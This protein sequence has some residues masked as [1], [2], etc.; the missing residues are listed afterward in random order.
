MTL[1]VLIILC[2]SLLQI[3]IYRTQLKR[4]AEQA[5][6]LPAASTPIA[7]EPFPKVSVIIPAY[8]EAANIQDCVMAV[9]SS[10][11][12]FAEQLEVW[13]VD[14]QSTDATLAIAQQLQ[15]R[16]GDSR[17]HVIQGQP[18]PQDQVWTGKNWACTQAV[19]KATGDFLLFIDA[20]VRLKPS[21]IATAV[22]TVQT[23]QIDLL[24][25]LPGVTCDNWG[26]W[27]VQPL[28]FNTL[29]G[30]FNLAAVND[31]HNKTAVAAGPFMLFRRSAYEHIGGHHSMAAEVLEDVEFSRRIKHSGLRLYMTIGSEIASVRMYP[32]WSSLWEGWTKNLY[33][34][35][36]RNLGLTLYVALMMVL[37]YGVPALSLA[38]I[39]AKSLIVPPNLGDGLAIALAAIA[40]GLHYD[41]LRLGQKITA[42]SPRYWWLGNLGGLLVAAIVIASLIKTE[43]GWG[44]TWRGRTLKLT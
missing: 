33:L 43:T 22:R 38:L 2:F 31:P 25:S 35:F 29:A 6:I 10:A 18:R 27:A 20:D 34:I 37:M 8:N 26:E 24:S 17:L 1:F 11:P 3:L 30:G 5:V 14:D 40:I 16:L 19:T 15:Q 4:S 7:G 28:I 12:W 44:W 41:L 39:L 9:L 32:T 23:Q 36:Q 21:A 13:V 42:I